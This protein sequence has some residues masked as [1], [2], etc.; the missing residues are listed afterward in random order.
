MSPVRK[1]PV[2]RSPEPPERDVV[3]KQDPSHT[4][5]DFLRDLRRA[6]TNQAKRKLAGPSGRG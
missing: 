6:S 2:K 3:E 1:R 5:A 4:R